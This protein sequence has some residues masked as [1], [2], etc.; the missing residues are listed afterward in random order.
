MLLIYFAYWVSNEKL[1]PRTKKIEK[2]R[3][4]FESVNALYE[5][6]ELILHAFRRRIFSNESKTR[7]RI[8]KTP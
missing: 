6:R 1:R 7:K 2:K 3:K 8:L 4:M 5:G